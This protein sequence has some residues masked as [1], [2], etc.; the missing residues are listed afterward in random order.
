MRRPAAPAMG[1]GPGLIEIKLRP[2][3]IYYHF[4]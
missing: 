4:A 2:G 3:F 1:A